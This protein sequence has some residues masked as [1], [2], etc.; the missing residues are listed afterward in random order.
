MVD[1]ISAAEREIAPPGRAALLDFGRIVVIGGGC[2]GSWYTQQLDRARSRGALTA[3]EIVVV[4]RD[5][6][7]KVAQQLA[8]GMYEG[9]PVRLAVSTWDDYLAEWLS[10]G[11]DALA[12]DTMVPS[13]LMPHL[14]LDWLM[15]RARA[16]WPGR[17]MEVAPLPGTPPTPWERAA[18]DARHYVSFATWTCPVNCIEPAK[19]PATRGPRDW[20]M[21][22]TIRAMADGEPRLHGAAIFHCEHRTYGVGMIDAAAIAAADL[23]VA[24]WGGQGPCNILVGTV[25]HCHGALGVLAIS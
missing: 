9:T 24:E 7:C 17:A 2:Y 15:A 16:R 14:C 10:A 18:P 8:Q 20:S 1:D 19:C 21:P 5:A 22:V 4:D 3:R 12:A 6:N 13:P 23:H 11:P 25:S